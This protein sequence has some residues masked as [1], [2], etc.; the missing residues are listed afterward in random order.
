MK[1]PIIRATLLAL[2]LFPALLTAQNATWTGAGGNSLWSTNDNW[3]NAT[4]PSSAL[5]A[6]FNPAAG[7]TVDIQATAISARSLTVTSPASGTM[8]I[9]GTGSLTLATGNLT[10]TGGAAAL[11]INPNIILGTSGTWDVNHST[12]GSTANLNIYGGISDEGNGYGIKKTGSDNLNLYGASTFS[13]GVEMNNGSIYLYNNAALGT[14]ALKVTGGSILSFSTSGISNAIDFSYASSGSSDWRM[15]NTAGFGREVTISGAI[16]DSG[17]GNASLRTRGEAGTWRFANTINIKGNI[18]FSSSNANAGANT[19]VLSANPTLNLGQGTLNL[20]Y[21]DSLANFNLLFDTAGTYGGFKNLTVIANKARNT[22]GGTQASGTVTLAPSGDI[23]LNNPDGGVNF[24]TLEKTAS[25]RINS[26][27]TGDATASINAAWQQVDAAKTA[28]ANS[29]GNAILATFSPKGAVEFSSA[30]G[31]TYTGGTTVEAGTLRV[32]NTSGSATGTGAVLVKS[33]ARL[34]G[35]GIIKPTGTNGV[36]ISDGATLAAGD[37][38]TPGTL[39]F[40]SSATTGALL[41]LDTGAT[42]EF[43]LGAPGSGDQIAIWNYAVGDLVFSNN[44]INIIDAGGLAEGTY[45]LFSFYSNAGTN[46][47]VVSGILNGLT[48]GDGLGAFADSRIE[49]LDNRINLVVAASSAIPEAATWLWI[50]IPGMM[51]IAFRTTFRPA[52]S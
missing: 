6:I 19:Y 27:I 47:S 44:A 7:L 23:Q 3:Q 21:L 25:T 5:N 52:K 10:K 29:T 11:N 17:T 4:P 41:T 51:S 33:S 37:A 40:D 36:R 42:L 35:T 1:A 38:S 14:G 39:R 16:S 22:I 12:G 45:T 15:A 31:N 18:S 9:N 50:A 2:G 28:A 46:T 8:F 13:G 34:D 48:L 49:Y 24:A 26:R 43:R 20:G 30:S 32:S